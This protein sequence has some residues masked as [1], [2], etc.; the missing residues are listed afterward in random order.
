MRR[1]Y[2]FVLSNVCL[3]ET[4]ETL[5]ADAPFQGIWPLLNGLAA[6]IY[7]TFHLWLGLCVFFQVK[8]VG[9]SFL[10]GMMDFKGFYD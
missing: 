9:F 8:V 4:F 1:I 5:K 2:G 3:T 10:S 7:V 6:S